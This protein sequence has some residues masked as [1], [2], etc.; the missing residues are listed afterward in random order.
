MF[1][2]TRSNAPRAG[3]PKATTRARW[4]RTALAAGA[5]TLTAGLL[6]S[7]LAC[8]V[9]NGGEA[10][11]AAGGAGAFG[12]SGGNGVG[13][14]GPAGGAGG[15]STATAELLDEPAIFA[16]AGLHVSPSGNDAAGDGSAAAPYRTVQY[17]L[18][19]VAGPG[20]VVLLHGGTYQEQVR[21]RHSNLTLQS[22]QG[23]RAH[24]T[25]PVS[26]D[27]NAPP[28][29]I[30]IDAETAGVTLRGLEVSGGFYSIYL[31]SQ[32]DYDNTPL[33]NA[34]ARNVVIEDCVV[35]DSGRDTIKLP[36]GCD[37]VT[38]RRCEIYNSGRSYP[39]GTPTEDKNAEGI[40]VVNSDNLRVADTYVHDAA[41]SCVYVK[42]GS[43]GTVIERVKAERCGD[44]GIALGFDTSPEFF[45]TRANPGYYEN[46]GG[47][48]R[49]CLVRDTGLAGIGLFASRDAR[50]LHN[51]IVHAATRGQAALYLGVAT[52]DYD[53]AAKRPANAN[54][55]IVGNIVDQSGVTDARCF[56]IR[57]GVEDQLG[58]LSGLEG[59]FALRTNL[60]FASGACAFSDSR[61]ASTLEGGDLAAWQAHAAGFDTGSIFR[62]PGLD[63]AG[64]LSASSPAVDAAGGATEGVR[65]DLDRQPRQAPYDLGA[66]ER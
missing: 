53:P 4:G 6:T 21:I 44:V 2:P 34:A 13:G 23:E 56:G 51:T 46:L 64:H 37:N 15:G 55:T 43:I 5:L 36:A 29:C 61:P 7:V 11:T 12:G 38:I 20:A 32:W 54:P 31:G 9:R 3:R 41:T 25:C 49:N 18:D 27:E 42:G 57:Y 48:V 14:G 24:V 16:T 63:A 33:D 45:D 39:P 8:V 17:V 65:Y 59:P 52:Q 60:Y 47:T 19:N 62:A 28:I 10:G 22:V 30:E 50:V 58:A 66:D 1:D 26:G 40:D 35:H